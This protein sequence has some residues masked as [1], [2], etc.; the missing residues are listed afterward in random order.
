[1]TMDEQQLAALFTR[2][3]EFAELEGALDIF[4]PFEAIGMVKQEIR[5]AYFLSYILDPQRPHGFGSG[6]LRAFLAAAADAQ[7]GGVH[8]TSIS[9]LAVHLMDLEGAIIRREWRR[10]DLLIEIPKQNLIITIELKIDSAEHGDQLFKYEKLVKAQ[11]PAAK[12]IF[13]FLTKNGDDPSDEENEQWIT[14][15]LDSVARALQPEADKA[16]GHPSAKALLKAYIDMLGR[17]H[18]T[19]ERLEKLAAALWTKHRAALEFLAERQPDTLSDAMS[20]LIGRKELIA[21]KL[22]GET[23]LDIVCDTISGTTTIYFAV[24]DWDDIAD[25]KGTARW[26]DSKRMILA[27][28]RAHRGEVATATVV[29]G[30]GDQDARHRIYQKLLHGARESINHPDKLSPDWKRI[31]SKTLCRLKDDD[32]RDSQSLAEELESGFIKAIAPSLKAYDKALR[33][34]H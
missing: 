27:Q 6:C 24:K 4:C 17:R 2:S 20:L 8:T 7:A 1:M 12:H 18:L 32:D 15:N 33:T 28:F 29:L 22:S 21:E 3:E 10:I 25:M 31:A 13:L 11:W 23:G 19:D 5:H 9:R 16:A 26:T 30:R 14:L 34:S